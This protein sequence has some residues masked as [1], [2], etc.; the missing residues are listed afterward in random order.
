MKLTKTLLNQ[1]TKQ[2]LTFKVGDNYQIT[3]DSDK[4]V[5]GTRINLTGEQIRKAN[6]YFDL[7]LGT[8]LLTDINALLELER[9]EKTSLTLK[10]LH[11]DKLTAC[12]GK[13]EARPILCTVE[14]ATTTLTATDS[15]KLISITGD[16][17]E[18]PQGLYNVKHLQ[19]LSKLYPGDTPI[20][21]TKNGIRI[22]DTTMI[23]NSEADQYPNWQKLFPEITPETPT[24]TTVIQKTKKFTHP[25]EKGAPIFTEITPEKIRQIA[26]KTIDG[27]KHEFM[28]EETQPLEMEKLEETV[29]LSQEYYSQISQIFDK[30]KVTISITGTLKPVTIRSENM[31]G[32]IMPIRVR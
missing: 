21:A 25:I 12:A 22:G 9:G 18:I 8:K 15:Y 20:F 13:D 17:H 19:F 23:P 1:I 2:G 5:N 16:F 6:P 24:A 28:L 26:Y 29:T 31:A 14:I 32:L 10:D 11:V 7:Q 30:Q 4:Q 3:L 27:T